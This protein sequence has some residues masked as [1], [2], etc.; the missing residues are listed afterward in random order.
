L[1][2]QG[3][4]FEFGAYR[5]EL[6]PEKTKEAY[7]RLP[8]DGEASPMTAYFRYLLSQG[9]KEALSLLSEMGIDPKKLTR[10]RPVSEPDENGDLLFLCYAPLCGRILAGGEA[11][12]R[13]SAEQAGMGLIFVPEEEMAEREKDFPLPKMELRFVIPLPFD[14]AYFS[15]FSSV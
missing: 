11:K 14:G 5:L 8:T 10:V 2:K 1:C 4:I 12:P 15:R 7:E 3:R 13:Q 6:F 9:D